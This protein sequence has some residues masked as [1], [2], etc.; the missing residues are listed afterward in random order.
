MQ[1]R[2]RHDVR[3]VSQS[4]S[5]L[6]AALP[7][8]GF[9]LH[10]LL[11]RLGEQGLLLISILLV[12][13][14]LLPW[15]PGGSTPFGLVVTLV[16]IGIM[17]NRVPWL[18]QWL[19]RRR[20]PAAR[21]ARVLHMGAQ[22]F[23]R[24]ERVLRPRLMLL[25][26]RATV[27]RVNGAALALA[28]VLLAAPLPIPFT[29]TFPAWAVLFLAAGMLERDGYMLVAGYLALLVSLTYFGLVVLAPWWLPEMV[30]Q[31]LPAGWLPGAGGR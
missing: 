19:S 31:W 21:L 3:P 8:E 16:G 11:E 13:P 10:E 7:E 4:L 29:N 18:P 24:I 26:E 14:F 15:L 6:A 22:V 20:F 17:L 25:T 23:A 9:T 12:V 1:A 2:F 28:G 5:E 30:P 27:N